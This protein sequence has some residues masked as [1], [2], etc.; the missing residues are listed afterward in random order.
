MSRLYDY[1][2]SRE[3]AHQGQLFF[4]NKTSKL[5]E[6]ELRSE[7]ESDSNVQLRSA[8]GSFDNYLAYMNERQDLIDS[9]GLKADWWDTGDALFDPET[10]YEVINEGDP[11]VD[12]KDQVMVLSAGGYNSQAAMHDL[13]TKYTGQDITE[14]R[15]N[16]R[17]DNY[18]W[19]GT[20]YVKTFTN[21]GGFA[22][23][24]TLSLM[25]AAIGA[26]ASPLLS[27]K[28]A[29]L[30]GAAL[31]AGVA[32]PAAPLMSNAM[33][34]GLGAGI[35][36]AATQY[37]LSGSVDPRSVL[38]AGVI[39][40]LNPGGM[41]A[42][43]FGQATNTGLNIVPDNVVGGFLQGSVN[44]ALGDAIATG[45]VSLKD[46]L[47]SGGQTAATFALKDA[48]DDT[49]KYAIEAEMKRIAAHRAAR[50]LPELTSEELYSAAYDNYLT[51][52]N[53]SGSMVG[54]PEDISMLGKTDMGGLIGKDGLLS[55]IPE[56]PTGWL[57]K[58][59]G[60]GAFST[61]EF[62][63]GPDGKK[64]TDV[65][66]LQKGI[67]PADVWLGNVDGWESFTTGGEAVVPNNDRGF[68]D[69]LADKQFENKY[70][71][72]PTEYIN[73]ATGSELD[74]V[75]DRINKVR[76]IIA[77]GPLDETYNFAPNPRGDS[78]YVGLLTGVPDE[79]TQ[80]A[81]NKEYVYNDYIDKNN[82]KQ[83][84]KINDAL[85]IQGVIDDANSV[86]PPSVNPN[87]ILNLSEGATNPNAKLPGSS[88]G[89]IDAVTN[90]LLSAFD[91]SND[92][93][94]NQQGGDKDVT[95]KVVEKETG[96]DSTT[97]AETTTDVQPETTTQ[98]ETPTQPVDTGP[99]DAVT[100]TPAADPNDIGNGVFTA[101]DGS[102]Y[103]LDSNGKVVLPSGLTVSE[104]AANGALEMAGI[105]P[106]YELPTSSTTTLPSG[107]GGVDGGGGRVKYL[108]EALPP[109]WTELFGYS[110]VS[111]YKK[112]R[113][114]VLEGMLG[115]MMG[116]AVNTND[117]Q[118][119]FNQDPY[120]KIGK[121][122]R[123]AGMKT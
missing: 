109:A 100:E 5:S 2:A 107:G 11:N 40:G 99:E 26:A 29:G 108:R 77:Y 76:Q 102:T 25:T 30:G 49:K 71:F 7:F 54:P 46:A 78:I 106:P 43:N 20:S 58:I 97:Q 94:S 27:A 47:I 67:N 32:G 70:G 85:L 51:M 123:D 83:Y 118:F 96:A 74:T 56:M 14:A 110:K 75:R 1:T 44:R 35:T 79:Y 105:I 50:R 59:M 120:Q 22:K 113:L 39:G 28:L 91:T 60:G 38:S 61:D 89:F 62:F 15:T 115:G 19:N 21:D 66:L 82:Q 114:R 17:G 41:L 81:V 121:S 88:Y 45:D 112:A 42:E 122:L 24:F 52:E 6:E 69:S 68:L 12:Y 36:N 90:G 95:N 111:P 101:H 23:D 84:E 65:E 18:R 93:S 80:G 9:G 13:Y 92:N 73:G 57:N 86:Q 34:Q 33:A 3:G 116:G 98:P 10:G 55:F 119:G 104:N 117:F 103:A 37:A 87:V 8:F 63:V 48:L 16:E 72:N 4:G 64:Y 53:T 31:P